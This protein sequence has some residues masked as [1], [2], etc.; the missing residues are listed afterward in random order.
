MIQSNIKDYIG[1]AASPV[2]KD[3]ERYI[4]VYCHEFLPYKNGDDGL[5]KP[6]T[7][8]ATVIDA[9]TGEEISVTVNLQDTI[10]CEYLGENT[11]MNIPDIHI[12]EMVKVM[13]FAGT[14]DFYWTCLDRKDYV[15]HVE[16]WRLS[17]ANERK[18][19]KELKDGNTYF[20]E[21]DTKNKKMIHVHTST[22]DGEAVGYDFIIDADASIVT[23][24]DTVGN[25]IVMKSLVPQIIST[26]ADGTIVDLIQTSIKA[27]APKDII[28]TAGNNIVIDAGNEIQN[29]AGAKFS[30]TAPE[31]I[32]K[33]SKYTRIT[34]Q[35]TWTG[36]GKTVITAPAGGVTINGL[37]LGLI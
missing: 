10:K 16:H 5:S 36:N 7:D 15:R 17:V 12:E 22:S 9:E 14:S 2:K 26:N 8:T 33:V 1:I 30:M 4:E 25:S 34:D 31:E 32:I 35:A 13:N 19:N 37:S 27:T 3:N 20:V 21:L 11:N 18:V 23:L 24:K 28:L 6:R 29:K